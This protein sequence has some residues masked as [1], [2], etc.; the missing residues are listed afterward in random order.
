MPSLPLIAIYTDCCLVIVESQN[1]LAK[2]TLY[3]FS[4]YKTENCLYYDL[5]GGLWRLA[6][7]SAKYSPSPLSRLIS[8]FYNPS[9]QVKLHWQYM[10]HFT[11]EDLKERIFYCIDHDDDVL[12]QFI[13]SKT[14]K[15][16]LAQCNTFDQVIRVLND[17]VFKP[18]LD[19][20]GE[21]PRY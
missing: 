15:S 3:A 16:K 2:S 5:S 21:R 18:N 4:R 20:I 11:L 10:G 12:T 9:F 1:W 14:L 13:G 8:V 17:C 6:L 7:D 19:L